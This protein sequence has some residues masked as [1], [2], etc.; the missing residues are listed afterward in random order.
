MT[1]SQT[2]NFGPGFVPGK[3]RVSRDAGARAMRRDYSQAQ[4]F[5]STFQEDERSGASASQPKSKA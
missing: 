5:D 2:D 4:N 1:N 3:V